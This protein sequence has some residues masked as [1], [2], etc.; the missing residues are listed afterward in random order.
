M[1]IQEATEKRFI[2]ILNSMLLSANI[3]K[4]PSEVQ[5]MASTYLFN[6]YSGREKAMPFISKL[7][8]N[9]RSMF[10]LIWNRALGWPP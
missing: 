7:V 10:Y 8:S 2:W 9:V 5:R 6:C 4:M 1:K 3:Q